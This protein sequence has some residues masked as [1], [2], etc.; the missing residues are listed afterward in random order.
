MNKV[1][2]YFANDYLVHNGSPC[3]ACG[4]CGASEE[5]SGGGSGKEEINHFKIIIS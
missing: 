2:N 3:N 5:G 1:Y 4:A